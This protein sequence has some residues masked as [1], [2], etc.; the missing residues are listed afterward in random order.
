MIRNAAI[1]LA[2]QALQA[3]L[4]QIDEYGHGKKAAMYKANLRDAI[5]TLNEMKEPAIGSM[6]LQLEP[7]GN[8]G[9]ADV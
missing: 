6:L 9:E 7:A 3:Q 8:N 5:A 2:V 1:R 4:D